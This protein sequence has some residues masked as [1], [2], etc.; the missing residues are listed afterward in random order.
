MGVEEEVETGSGAGGRYRVSTDASGREY[1]EEEE[2]DGTEESG[3]SGNK[4]EELVE[5]EV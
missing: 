1:E 2:E 5:E 4:V 3:E